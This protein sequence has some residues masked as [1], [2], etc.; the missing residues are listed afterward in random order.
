MLKVRLEA[1]SR[2]GSH[3]SSVEEK[4]SPQQSPELGAVEGG[5]AAGAARCALTSQPSSFPK[6]FLLS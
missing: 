6:E 5:L 4:G 1:R 2:E 3:G